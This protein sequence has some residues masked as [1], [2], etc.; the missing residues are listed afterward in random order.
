ML[1]RYTNIGLLSVEKDE[2]AYG[3]VDYVK[4][5]MEIV[6]DGIPI[7]QPVPDGFFA[8]IFSSNTIEQVGDRYKIGGKLIDKHD[9]IRVVGNEKRLLALFISYGMFS[10]EFYSF[11]KFEVCKILE[12]ALANLRYGV[13]RQLCQ[14]V[15]SKLLPTTLGAQIDHK[16]DRRWVDDTF[17]FDILKHQEET[18]QA[19]M[20]NRYVLGY[21]G[22]LAHASVGTGKAQPLTSKIATPTGWA[23]MGE[24]KVGDLVATQDGSFTKVTGIYPQGKKKILKVTFRD[25]REVRCTEDHLWKITH[26]VREQ[27]ANVITYRFVDKV[28]DTKTIKECIGSKCTGYYAVPV[29]HPVQYARKDVVIHPYIMGVILGDG[30]ISGSSCFIHTQDMEVLERMANYILPDYELVIKE[31]TNS[32]GNPCYK[33]IIT[34]TSAYKHNN[35]Y[36]EELHRYNLQGKLSIDKHIPEDYLYNDVESRWEL[37][38]GLID[39]DGTVSNPLTPKGVKGKIA[40]CGSISYS[41]S[42]DQLALDVQQLVYSLGGKCKICTKLPTY[43]HHGEKRTGLLNYIL[44]ISFEDPTMAC[45]R[46]FLRNRLNKNGQYTK[47]WK[48]SIKSIT[49]DGEEEAQCISVEHPSKLYLTDNYVVTHNTALSLFLMEG[50][51]NQ[52][53]K[54]IVLCPL[55]TVYKVWDSTLSGNPGTGFKQPQSR[56]VMKDEKGYNGEKYIICHYE[57]LDKLDSFLH[58]LPKGR[59]GVI[60]DECHNLTDGKSK[61]TDLALKLMDKLDVN[62]LILLSGTPLK[63]GYMELAVLFKFLDKSFTNVILKRYQTLYKSANGLL[64]SILKDRYNSYSKI[65]KKD[66]IELK[67]L[68]TINLKLK[69]PENILRPYYLDSIKR[70]LE[71]YIRT[72]IDEIKKNMSTYVNNYITLRDLGLS[73]NRKVSPGLV[74]MYMNNVEKIRRTDPR[75]LYMLG[76]IP[77]DV[78]KFEQTEILAYLDKDQKPVFKEAKTI[79]KYPV[80]KVQ[81]EA[82]ANVIGRARINC[83][84]MMAEYLDYNN[85]ILA[86]KK[87]T[88]IFSNYVK[89]CDMAMNRTKALN[90][91]PIGVYGDTSKDLSKLVGEFNSNPKINPIVTTYKSLSTG[92][93]LI[94]ANTIIC[95]DLP[96]R[97]YLYEQAIGRAWRLG[98]DSEVNVFILELDTTIPTINSRNIDIIKFFN[99]EVEKITGVKSSTTIEGDTEEQDSPIEVVSNEHLEDS[100]VSQE[101]LKTILSAGISMLPLVGA[102]WFLMKREQAEANRIPRVTIYCDRE[103]EKLLSNGDNYVDLLINMGDNFV[104]YFREHL[105]DTNLNGFEKVCDVWDPRTGRPNVEDTKGWFHDLTREQMDYAVDIGIKTYPVPVELEKIL[106]TYKKLL[107]TKVKE[108]SFFVDTQGDTR[109]HRDTILIKNSKDFIENIKKEMIERMGDWYDGYDYE[110]YDSINDMVIHDKRYQDTVIKKYDKCLKLAGEL[111]TIIMK[112]LDECNSVQ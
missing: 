12:Y 84:V 53:D 60:I 50:L 101:I 42:S 102:A 47:N 112:V 13:N 96:F 44:H 85:I 30:G 105:H 5:D 23:T 75:N 7:D 1:N 54:V 16:F 97:M 106:Q 62:D 73:R 66:V 89:V 100:Y 92:V 51:H 6:Q 70:E 17:E 74:N 39:T 69:I 104:E 18:I 58:N 15:V 34:K 36:L 32:N 2:E 38:R 14:M 26:L 45:T 80:L 88:I 78:N 86:A 98:Q 94:T 76:D 61:R 57:A 71:V 48:L 64:G 110:D 8:G 24:I 46:S 31:E 4:P 77:K 11:F 49:E 9:F 55:N 25:G 52:V 91:N 22:L 59:T 67:K 35:V 82:L 93:P 27:K 107:N 40:I 37:L 19:Y 20:Y 21:R 68:N 65:V 3:Y 81:G 79:Y 108:Y 41:T 109:D 63:S 56:Y 33:S 87:K 103:Y 83:H 99:D 72:R 90:Y 29:T 111:F 10:S 95:I 28:V 43:T